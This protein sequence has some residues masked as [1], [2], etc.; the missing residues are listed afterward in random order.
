MADAI[1]VYSM[2]DQFATY[3]LSKMT[4]YG[5]EGLVVG[6]VFITGFLSM[7]LSNTGKDISIYLC[8]YTSPTAIMN[9]LCI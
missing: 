2:H 7:F 6:F 4:V 3:L 1:E 9:A 8:F 5:N